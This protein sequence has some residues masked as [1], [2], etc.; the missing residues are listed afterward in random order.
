MVK[1][2]PHLLLIESQSDKLMDITSDVV[3]RDVLFIS[4]YEN[5]CVY[6]VLF[7]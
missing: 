6:K 7:R 1:Y 2:R 3:S 4:D 5:G